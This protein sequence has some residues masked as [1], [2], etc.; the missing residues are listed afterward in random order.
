MKIAFSPTLKQAAQVLILTAVLASC[1]KDDGI[2]SSELLVYLPGEYSSANNTIT[3]PLL[4]TPIAVS[5]VTMA[6]V[7]PRATREAAADI[8]VTIATDTS[9]VRSYNK[10]NGTSMLTLPENTYRLVNP[11]KFRIKAGSVSTDSLQ[12]EL[13]HPELLKDP[14]GYLLPLR[15]TQLE[16]ADKGAAISSNQRAAYV[17]VTYSYTNIDTAQATLAGTLISRT[18]WSVTVSNT[19]AGA[20][21]PAMLD[22][23]NTTAWRSSNSTTAAKWVI[24][25]MGSARTIKGLRFT[26]NYVAVAENPTA[27]TVSTSA[28]NTLFAAQGSWKGTGPASS[29]SA[30]NPDIKN[31][32]FIA[33]VTARYIRF[34]ITSLVSGGRVGIGELNAVQ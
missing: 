4:H 33:P 8:D 2:N 34:D 32:N 26:P 10:A 3:L 17:N 16:G 14:A 11:G 25:D 28:D 12:I 19:T 24:L 27:I 30:T 29:S 21:G 1:K 20:L 18:G 9:L 22:G 5:G 23:S 7:A 15:I 31:I 13:T 6:K